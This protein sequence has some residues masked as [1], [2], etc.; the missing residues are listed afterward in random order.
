V[1]VGSWWR[2]RGRTLV[3]P[4]NCGW[5]IAVAGSRGRTLVRLYAWVRTG[6]ERRGLIH[7]PE[8]GRKIQDCK[9]PSQRV[10]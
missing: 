10:L 6:G 4:Y 5:M 2:A 3:R 9:S 7:R 1:V 8:L